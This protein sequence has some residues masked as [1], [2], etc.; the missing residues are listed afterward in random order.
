[1]DRRR[2]VDDDHGNRERERRRRRRRY[3]VVHSSVDSARMDR[4]LRL[5][6]SSMHVDERLVVPA[7]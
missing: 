6:Y 2:Q 3:G 1:M 7:N 5:Y 4:I